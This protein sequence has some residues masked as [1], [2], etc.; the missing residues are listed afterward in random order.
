MAWALLEFSTLGLA[1]GA[2]A[3]KPA[4]GTGG[5]PHAKDAK[6]VKAA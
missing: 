6:D 1:G 2:V 5:R 3:A 4:A